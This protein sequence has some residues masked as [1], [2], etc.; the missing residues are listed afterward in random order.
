MKAKYGP[1]EHTSETITMNTSEHVTL[2]P[3]RGVR[4]D[5]D[6][7]R[8]VRIITNE[9]NTRAGMTAG[10]RTALIDIANKYD[11]A[12]GLSAGPD[13]GRSEHWSEEAKVL[14][15]RLRGRVERFK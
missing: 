9:N 2:E 12:C 6:L 4:T 1:Y 14:E 3:M 15:R 13:P 11:V 10:Q 8:I 5:D 7:M